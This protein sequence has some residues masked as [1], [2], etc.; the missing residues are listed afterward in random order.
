MFYWKEDGYYTPST[1]YTLVTVADPK[2][3]EIDLPFIA[4]VYYK[5]IC[6]KPCYRQL[7]RYKSAKKA[8]KAINRET[9]DA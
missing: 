3:G 4:W 5:P 1:L 9:R 7:G 6:G 2:L 8:W